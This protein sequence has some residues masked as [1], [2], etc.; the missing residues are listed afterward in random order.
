MNK[1]ASR[2]AIAQS[3]TTTEWTSETARKSTEEK[4]E[5]WNAIPFVE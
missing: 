1:S 5:V 3:G 4:G 2:L